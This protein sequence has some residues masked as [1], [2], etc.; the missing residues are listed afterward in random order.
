[1]A[2]GYNPAD[3]HR[4]ALKAKEKKKNKTERKTAREEGEAKKSTAGR[5]VFVMSHPLGPAC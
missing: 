5:L 1:M 2:K 4:K 3:A